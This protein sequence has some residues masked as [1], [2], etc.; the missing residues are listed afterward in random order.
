MGLPST[1]VIG[2]SP[3]YALVW[4]YR[5]LVPDVSSSQPSHDLPLS[6]PNSC[7]RRLTT[8][9]RRLVLAYACMNMPSRRRDAIVARRD[10]EGGHW[11]LMNGQKGAWR[12]HSMSLGVTV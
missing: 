11:V 6:T 1:N 2:I 9:H 7:T 3:R 8:Q 5:F 12:G 4:F 10:L